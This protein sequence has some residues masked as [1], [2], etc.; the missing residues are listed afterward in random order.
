M[1][2]IDFLPNNSCAPSKKL[3][4][5]CANGVSY[6]VVICDSDCGTSTSLAY[7]NMATGL[8]ESTPPVDFVLGNCMDKTFKVGCI[9]YLETETFIPTDG[10]TTFTVE[11]PPNGDVRFSRNG[12]TLTDLAATVSGNV[13]TYIPSENNGEELLSTDRVEISYVYSVCD[14][15]IEPFVDCSGKEILNGSS[16]VTCNSLNPTSFSIDGTTGLI[17]T[18]NGGGIN[19]KDCIG[20]DLETNT[21]VVTCDSLNPTHF[22]IDT[23]TGQLSSA[24]GCIVSGSIQTLANAGQVYF[25]LASFHTPKGNPFFFLNGMRLPM[26]AINIIAGETG[27]PV[28]PYF[29]EY[30]P[31][32]NGGYVLQAGDRFQVDYLYEE[33]TSLANP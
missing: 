4:E 32:E 23:I 27:P 15:A 19:L 17:S 33:G 9:P 29:F 8:T 2:N 12:S 14:V 22:E 28:V 10:Q 26:A 3:V 18:T 25:P 21:Q 5:G 7:L 20:N 1:D 30:L 13:V 11:N 16:I 24:C 6:M 31:A